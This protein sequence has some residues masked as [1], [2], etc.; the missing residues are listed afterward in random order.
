[1][2]SSPSVVF[3]H[4]FTGAFLNSSTCNVVSCNTNH[5]NGESHIHL[6]PSLAAWWGMLCVDQHQSRWNSTKRATP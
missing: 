4:L 6:L 1:M 2:S 3:V 5:N